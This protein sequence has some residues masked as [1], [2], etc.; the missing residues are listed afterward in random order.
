MPILQTHDVPIRRVELAKSELDLLGDDDGRVVVLEAQPGNVGSL[1]VVA[2][3]LRLVNP[4][5]VAKP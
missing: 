4:S 1:V 3:E 5:S 2:V